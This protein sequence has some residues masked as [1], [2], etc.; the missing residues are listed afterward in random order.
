MENVNERL[1]TFRIIVEKMEK[2][3]DSRRENIGFGESVLLVLKNC[4]FIK[5]IIFMVL[6]S[7]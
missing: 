7:A 4:K 2:L 1:M 6:V 3:E 5:N